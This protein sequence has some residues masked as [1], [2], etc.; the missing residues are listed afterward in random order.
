MVTRFNSYREFEA[1]MLYV[2]SPGCLYQNGMLTNT[3]GV[4]VDI[5]DLEIIPNFNAT[6]QL[7]FRCYKVKRDDADENEHFYNLFNSLRNRRLIFADGIGFF[8]IT[9]VE[10]GYEDQIFYKD[11]S[12]ESCES[13]LR[14]KNLPYIEDGTYKFYTGEAGSPGMIE[15][16]MQYAPLY[17]ATHSRT[18]MLT[19][20]FIG[21]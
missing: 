21:Y 17:R 3:A 11:I 8:M 2:C 6:S 16:L 14:T 1:P 4:L 19:G 15:L 7:N 12:A 18:L 13:E 10:D 5:S 20:W 9:N